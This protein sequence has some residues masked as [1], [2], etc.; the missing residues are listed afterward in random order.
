M[1]AAHIPDM[2]SHTLRTPAGTPAGG[3]FTDR[4]RPDATATLTACRGSS[5]MV[6]HWSGKNP[7]PPVAD[8]VFGETEMAGMLR[9]GYCQ[10]EV[11]VSRKWT[12]GA[13]QIADWYFGVHDVAGGP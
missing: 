6:S 3:Q 7:Y 4:A 13:R 5:R 9:C 10:T 8:V 11:P 1:T 2:D 12:R